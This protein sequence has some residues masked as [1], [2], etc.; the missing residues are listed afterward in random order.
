MP[1]DT[2][3]KLNKEKRQAILSA[4]KKEFSRAELN[5]ISVNK[6]VE[7]SKISKGSFYLY[8]KDKD[9]AI[10]YILKEFIETKKKDIEEILLKNSGDIFK[11]AFFLFEDILLNEKRQEDIK[12]IQNV[13]QG[14]AAK[15]INVMNIENGKCCDSRILSCINISEYNINDKLE[16]KVFLELIV[17]TLGSE[18]I[19]VLNGRNEY[20]EAKKELEL[21][22]RIIKKGIVKEEYR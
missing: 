18:I 2:F 10:Q 1:T 6:I 8:F 16:I 14:I 9:E 20:N 4:I 3:Y 15:G 11:A 21:Q 22:F 19:S 5:D 13:I 12:F 17:R 7:D